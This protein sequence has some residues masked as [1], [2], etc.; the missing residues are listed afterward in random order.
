MSGFSTKKLMRW[1][2]GINATYMATS[3]YFRHRLIQKHTD[4]PRSSPVTQAFCEE[5]LKS[6][7]HS[8]LTSTFS[9]STVKISANHPAFCL[10]S[11][12]FKEVLLGIPK[13]LDDWVQ[14]P[15]NT[16]EHLMARAV[17]THELAH[18]ARY[19]RTLFDFFEGTVMGSLLGVGAQ[20]SYFRCSMLF[21]CAAPLFVLAKHALSRQ[22]EFDADATLVKNFPERAAPLADY[23]K[24][25]DLSIGMPHPLLSTH[26]SASARVQK[27]A[28]DYWTT[29]RI[30][31]K[32]ILNHVNTKALKSELDPYEEA[33]LIKL[34]KTIG[35]RIN[36]ESLSLLQKF[37]LSLQKEETPLGGIARKLTFPEYL[38]RLMHCRFKV[39][40]MDCHVLIPRNPDDKWAQA[41]GTSGRNVLKNREMLRK[42]GTLEDTTGICEDY[43]SLPEIIMATLLPLSGISLAIGTGT[44]DGGVDPV[45]DL[46]KV[47]AR[48]YFITQAFGVECRNGTSAH[49]DLAMTARPATPNF[50]WEM[51]V[52]I[53]QN[54]APLMQVAHA[55]YGNPLAFET[56]STEL[57]HHPDFMPV[58]GYDGEIWY[59]YKPAYQAR[60]KS[61]FRL[62]LSQA[63]ATLEKYRLGQSFNIKGL[64]LG[65]FGFFHHQ[66][67][68]ET[69]VQEALIET[70][71]EVKLSYIKQINLINFPS[72]LEKI[73]NFEEIHTQPV[74]WEVTKIQGIVIKA[75]Y[76]N[77]LD[78]FTQGLDYPVGGTHSCADSASAFGNEYQMG[79]KRE[80]SDDP[81]V[82]ESLFNP[83]VFSNYFL[84]PTTQAKPARTAPIFYEK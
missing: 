48:P 36:Q 50:D 42:I 82:A 2:L 35:I 22:M 14:H 3:D 62:L 7:H 25:H 52:K 13:E 79:G 5:T 75:G 29:Q 74:L 73:K 20:L 65:A 54:S 63:D 58:E 49:L 28:P 27:L 55:I 19:H 60:L 12:G 84:N 39:A 40:F 21:L 26:P 46:K 17:L 4:H 61:Q 23:L 10:Y 11:L 53:I 30:H 72:S 18:K 70:L 76:C 32:L 41:V 81:A 43:L 31:Q 38:Q 69:L 78:Q 56:P 37:Y 83:A 6:V 16:K 66:T 15:Q 51:S 68:L 24:K 47:S 77:P 59:L 8:D 45:E 80:S 71:K 67:L 57:P 64:G 33:L 1:T 44:R 34:D 9:T